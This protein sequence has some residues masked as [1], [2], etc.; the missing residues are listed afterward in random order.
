MKFS[1]KGFFSKCDQIRKKLRTWSH[2]L[3][4]EEIL[5]EKVHILY[6]VCGLVGRA[7]S[8]K[9]AC[10]MRAIFQK[11]G[12]KMYKLGKVFGNLDKNVQNLKIF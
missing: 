8:R 3:N 7:Y 1:I 4:T 12:K 6:S 5:N 2:L 10:T 11:K 9:Y